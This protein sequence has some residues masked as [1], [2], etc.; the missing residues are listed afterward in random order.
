MESRRYE[1][2]DQF[3]GFAILGMVIVNVLGRFPIMPDTFRHVRVNVGGFSFADA[4]APFFVF[5][6]GMGFRLSFMKNQ[7]RDGTWCASRNAAYRYLT[8]LAIS[9]FVYKFD[10]SRIFWDALTF[11]GFG[12]L[13]ALPVIGLRPRYRILAAFLYLAIFQLTADWKIYDKQLELFLWVFPLLFG[14]IIADWLYYE[15]GFITNAMSI[16]LGVSLF[17]VGLILSPIW[18]IGQKGDM[19]A[20]YSLFYT[21]I[22]FLVYFFFYNIAGVY[23]K[24]L[25]HLTVLGRNAL[26]IY[27]VHYIVN[28]DV[29][30]IIPTKDATVWLALLSLLIVYFACYC[31]AAYL[32]RRKYYI[33]V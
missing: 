30:R 5:I 26:I 29:R 2:I 21:G 8:L 22:S 11:I 19:N 18:P 16:L 3:R 4:V 17:S 12:G 31:L 25:P 24:P 10:L 28:S 27:V 14:T 13:L 33:T 20:T 32:N 15:K 6:V 9:V 1:S 23:K 7:T